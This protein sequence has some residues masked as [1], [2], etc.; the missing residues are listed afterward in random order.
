[1]E[2]RCTHRGKLHGEMLFNAPGAAHPHQEFVSPTSTASDQK[3]P[4]NLR[5]IEYGPFAFRPYNTALF[6]REHWRYS[7]LN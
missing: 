2:P 6:I 7:R 1:M 4:P 5:G 3:D